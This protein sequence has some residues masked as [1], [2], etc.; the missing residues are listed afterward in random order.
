[1]RVLLLGAGFSRNWNGLLASEMLGELSGRLTDLPDVTSRLLKTREFETVL[2]QL[3]Q[4]AKGGAGAQ[5]GLMRLEAAVLDVFGAM[6]ES[7]AKI[8][9]LQ[10]G[11]SPFVEKSVVG[12]LERFDAIFTLNQDLLLECHFRHGHRGVTYPGLIPPPGWHS[13]DATDLVKLSWSVAPTLDVTPG[14]AQPVYKLHGSVNWHDGAQKTLVIGG[15]KTQA[16]GSNRLLAWYHREFRAALMAGK[17]KLM[18]VGYSFGDDHI[19]QVIQEATN[20]AQLSVYLVDPAG[21]D[22][23]APRNPMLAGGLEPRIH[24]V[25]LAGVS[26]RPFINAFRDDDVQHASFARFLAGP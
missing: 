10:D 19:N 20:D 15:G 9:T 26:V 11:A 7:F 2:A 17:T 12:F 23:I 21:L 3:Q 18:V 6:N 13:I 14:N 1:V 25:R 24:G 16:V 8:R 5:N 4:E 22:V